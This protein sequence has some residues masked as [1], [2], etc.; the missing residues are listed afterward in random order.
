VLSIGKL[1]QGQESYYLES[2]A[3]GIEDYYTG[4]GEA[5]GRW[6][7]SAARTLRMEGEVDDDGLT[8]VLGG[9]HPRTS[10]Q[11]T[12]RRGGTR[13][14]G[15]DLTF[16]A[17][18]SVSL[19]FGLG[20]REVSRQARQA[21]DR[22][23]DA[24]LDY[25][26]RHAAVARRGLGG[27]EL[28]PGNGFV[29]AAFRHRT[30]RAG[31]P[32][33]HT[34]VL[35]ANMTRGPDGRWTALDGRRLYA[36][37]KTGGYL[38][39]AQLRAELVRR[40]GVEWTPVHNGT[41]EIAGV[42]AP[43]M[44]AFSRRR[45]EI[46]QAMTDRGEHTAKAA[47][48][49]TLDSRKAKDYGVGAE[50]IR[51]RWAAK[52]RRLGFEPAELASLT[53]RVSERPMQ[54]HEVEET[55]TRLGSPQGLTSDRASF[56][57]RDVIQAW[58]D[59]LPQGADVRVAESLADEF[60]DSEHSVPLATDVRGLTHRDVI[61]RA[62]G[63]VIAATSEERRHSTPELLAIEKRLIESTVSRRDDGVGV[64]PDPAVAAAL[65]RRPTLSDEQGA[66]VRRLT[67]SGDGVQL[68]TG[69]A[70]TGKTFALDAAREAWQSEGYRVIGAAVAR[71]AA[72]ELQDGAGIESTSMAALL[73]DLRLG[74]E[75]ALPQRAVVVVDE[76][77]MAGT[78]QLGELLD[79]AEAARAKVVL[80]GDPQQLPEIDAGGA[81]RALLTRTDPIELHVNRRQRERWER[82]A[83][84]Q[85]RAGRA[86][87]AISRYERHGRVVLGDGA[88]DVRQRLVADWWKASGEGEAAMIA[89]R[90]V[91]V[92]DLNA[93]AR[94]FM[95]ASGQ[96]GPDALRVGDREF[97][98][99]DQ[100]VTL[101]NARHLGV[102]N[103]TRGVV[104]AVDANSL[105]LGVRTRDGRDVT[106]PRTYL[107]TTTQLG[108]ATLDHGYAITGHKAQGMTTGKAFVLGTEDLYREWGYVAMSR[109]SVENHLYV[110]APRERERDE[111]APARKQREPLEALIGSLE[112]SQSQ[113][114]ALDVAALDGVGRMTTTELMAERQRLDE[115]LRRSD[116]RRGE[117]ER[118]AT[119][120]AEAERALADAESRMAAAHGRDGNALATDRAIE[121]HARER[122]QELAA[123]QAQLEAAT[124]RHGRALGDPI[125]EA[126]R[127][128]AVSEELERRGRGRVRAAVIARPAYLVNELGPY[129]HRRS[130]RRAWQRAAMRIEVYRQE[131]G[132]NDQ[133][134]A[135]GEKSQDLQQRSALREVRREIE[136]ARRQLDRQ[137]ARTASGRE[138]R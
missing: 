82:A 98:V 63:R 28:V 76:A 8:A 131:F 87:E 20:D 125:Q 84:D 114:A 109:G 88:E 68:V 123:R 49:A 126:V 30:S 34:H 106:L 1:G 96:L 3:Q 33:L 136:R 115:Q 10:D 90:R 70:G 110:V 25:V 91:D 99:G 133:Q 12:S 116:Q 14:P 77:S 21:H 94:E 86:E 61:R 66:M 134:R 127:Y 113:T 60:L 48:I 71:R 2:V 43:V 6:V 95:R 32:Q 13:V 50:S 138:R 16:S 69:K 64:V 62:D 128:K 23:V 102:V 54:R 58:C 72:H 135:L 35:V 118:I 5:P 132:I 29:A 104:T 67:G 108:G 120:R 51:D 40:L 9:A 117:V 105:A 124:A 59:R 22:A 26:E 73:Q 97:A 7:G 101:K 39:Q 42:P 129:P 18:K 53:R 107:E 79:F 89:A 27:K 36:H 37:A 4:T 19:L 45:I 44:R 46:E 38:Y 57:R 55:I 47:Q 130:K 81:F 15:F 103:G 119:Q 11:L 56:T 93:R 65:E 78:R 100:V 17:P 92:A 74:G 41:A 31:D 75:Y 122:V 112:Y 52:A 80:V 111:Y 83:L 137:V 24:A 85:L 121:A